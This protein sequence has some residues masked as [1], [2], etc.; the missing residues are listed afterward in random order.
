M[1]PPMRPAAPPVA[2]QGL[3]QFIRLSDITSPQKAM[4]QIEIRSHVG[5]EREPTL[6]SHSDGWKIWTLIL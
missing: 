1:Q 5:E 4:R 2:L 6:E 3:S